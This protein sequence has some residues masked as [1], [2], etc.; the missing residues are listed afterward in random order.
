MIVTGDITRVTQVT[1]LRLLLV[2]FFCSASVCV[3]ITGLSVHHYRGGIRLTFN[4]MNLDVVAQPV[5][6]YD[7]ARIS[8]SD[9]VQHTCTCM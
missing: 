2:L 8:S 5:F 7:D 6:V 1:T 3:V 9:Q 4:G